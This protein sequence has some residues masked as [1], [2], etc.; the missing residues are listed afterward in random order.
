M[1]SFWQEKK[2]RSAR[3]G[4]R[5]QNQFIEDEERRQQEPAGRGGPASVEQRPQTPREREFAER[6]RSVLGSLQTVFP[7][8]CPQLAAEDVAKCSCAGAHVCACTCM[9]SLLHNLR[10]VWLLTGS[11]PTA[12]ILAFI[13]PPLVGLAKG[14]DSDWFFMS[15][16]AQ[17]CKFS[18]AVWAER[19]HQLRF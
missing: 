13:G 14:N 4:P 12:D 18:A 5:K 16:A 8:A 3:R 6:Y 9:V 17:E 10:G 19:I 1:A 11:L 2:K 15:I 7:G